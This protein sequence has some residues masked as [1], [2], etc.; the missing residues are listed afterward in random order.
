M[1]LYYDRRSFHSAR[2]VAASGGEEQRSGGLPRAAEG[3]AE[4]GGGALAKLAEQADFQ[5]DALDAAAIVAVTDRQGRILSVNRKFCELSGYSEAELLGSTH[6]IVCSGTHDRG[7]FRNLY[8]TIGRGEVWH[9]VICNRAKSGHLYWVDTTIVPHRD[10]SGYTAIRFDVTP[11]KLAEQRLEHLANV[12]PLTDLPNRR[13]YMHLLEQAVGRGDR[14][15]TAILDLDHFKDVNDSAGHDTGDRLLLAV[16]DVL[17]S[18]IADDETVARIGGDEFALI[19]HD[20]G[21]GELP[22]TLAAIIAAVGN[23]PAAPSLGWRA[24]ASLGA[25]RFPED[26]GDAGELLKCSDLALYAA[27]QDGRGCF[28]LFD[29]RLAQD[30]EWRAELR[31]AVQGALALGEMLVMYQPI[32][33]LTPHRPLA[34]EALLRWRRADGTLLTPAVFSSVF[35]DEAIA[36]DIGVFVLDQVLR[37]IARWTAAGVA[38]RSIAINATLGDLRGTRFVDMIAAAIGLGQVRGDQICVEITE[39][40][41]LD[42]GARTVWQ[43]IER[44][45]RCGVLI[46]FDDFGTGFASLTHL[47]Q[48]PIDHVKIDRSFIES[49]CADDKDVAIVRSV[50][51]LAHRLNLRVVAEGVEVAEQEQLLRGL[52]CDSIQGFLIAPAM[53]ERSATAL[54]QG[55]AD[56]LH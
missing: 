13:R 12:D 26:G 6:R 1:T 45:H 31:S 38:F 54:T 53:C 25:A 17:R 21:D 20:R 7:F 34:F 56:A 24:Q 52:G 51:E 40:M 33:D 36:A 5:R 3:L 50:I 49:I 14:I 19:L 32:V 30:A 39:G 16:A 2:P 46:A 23:V 44:L 37:Q 47:R 18:I 43:S 29:K 35:E 9:D 22:R 28:R 27:K 8:A 48:L 55:G 4:T 10:G 15:A 41:L 42:R 11:Q